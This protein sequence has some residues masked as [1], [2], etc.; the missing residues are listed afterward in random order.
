MKIVVAVVLLGL[1]TSV[2]GGDVSDLVAGRCAQCH[3]TGGGAAIPGWPAIAALSP[4]AFSGKL[5]GY[6][7]LQNPDSVMTQAAH[8]LTDDEID[9]LTIYYQTL[10][11]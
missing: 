4:E 2:S 6:R 3:G 9:G 1:A 7:S 10:G 5:K 8:D 11:E